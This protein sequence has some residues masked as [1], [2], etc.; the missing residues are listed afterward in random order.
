MSSRQTSTSGACDVADGLE[1]RDGVIEAEVAEPSKHWL[2]SRSTT[3]S[4]GCTH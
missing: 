2:S 1:C 3:F 4:K